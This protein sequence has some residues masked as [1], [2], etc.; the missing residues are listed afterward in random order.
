[1]TMMTIH[2]HY[3]L[4]TLVAAILIRRQYAYASYLPTSTTNNDSLKNSPTATPTPL[5]TSKPHSSGSSSSTTQQPQH[6][7][8]SSMDLMQFQSTTASNLIA[9]LLSNHGDIEIRQIAS[10]S[11][12]T[13]CAALFSQGHKLGYLYQKG[14]DNE[15]LKDATGKYIPTDPPV[16]LIPDE[17]I[18]LSSGNSEDFYCKDSDDMAAKYTAGGDADLKKGVDESN[19]KNN[20]I[21]DAC[22]LQ[23]QFR[24]T[25][26]DYIPV[27]TFRYS[28]GSE[29]YYEY[30]N[31]A[32]NDVFG[33]YLNGVNIARLPSST[34]NS[35]I[36][37][38][39]NVNF[40]HNKNYFHGNDP[41][42]GWEQHQSSTMVNNAPKMEM[43]Y[44]NIEA[45]GFTDTLTAIGTPYSNSSMWNTIKLAV[46]DVGD[47]L[48][49]SWVILEK[50]SF[51]CVDSSK[52]AS[53]SS[54]SSS[55][56]CLGGKYRPSFA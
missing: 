30:A 34:T 21:F 40:L 53:S 56:L 50:G 51:A 4:A 32:F 42:I 33:F 22:V 26:D 55:S 19:G 43:I 48:L 11:H 44:P 23:F 13:Q 9:N 17:G 14:P 10:S 18:I 2:H 16:P 39:T 47:N 6:S 25:S 12:I 1:M 45:D 20:V 29:E 3:L 41:G 24:C 15:L 7:S 37:S 35:D 31:S 28:F 38:I 54:S 36:V 5:P 49:D 46:G 8:S 52:A 27:V